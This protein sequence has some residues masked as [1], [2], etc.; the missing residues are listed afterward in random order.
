MT[1]NRIRAYIQLIQKL[2]DCPE[3]EEIEILREHEDLIDAQ[4]LYILEQAAD[5]AEEEGQ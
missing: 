4:F 2:L 3:G 5:K 1:D